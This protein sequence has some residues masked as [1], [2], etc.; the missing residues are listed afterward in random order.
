MVLLS[1][2]NLQPAGNL[3]LLANNRRVVVEC[4]VMKQ[5]LQKHVSYSDQIVILLR[6]VERVQ[7]CFFCLLLNRNILHQ[8]EKDKKTDGIRVFTHYTITSTASGHNHLLI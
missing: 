5:R 2:S 3:S 6:F 4:D 1:I 8:Y 7:R